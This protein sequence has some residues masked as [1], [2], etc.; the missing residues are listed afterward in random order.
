M[1]KYSIGLDI[2]AQT[3]HACI[4]GIDA[5]QKVTV[6]SSCK[7]DNT[8]SGFKQLD[9][10]ANKHRKLK[11][12]PLVVNMEA[13]GVYYE[14][15][16]LYLFKEGYSVSVLLPNK[17]KKWMQ[18]EGLK[19]KNDKID[20][21]SSRENPRKG[22]KRRASRALSGAPCVGCALSAISFHEV[23]ICNFLR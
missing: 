13:T 22:L 14:N 18:S 9:Q 10:W 20:A 11:N 12:V 2:S 7:I 1:L 15:C 5:V 4:S 16:A 23:S 3:I 17:A 6:K 21:P 19:S 8:L